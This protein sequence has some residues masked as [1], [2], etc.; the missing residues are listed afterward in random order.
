MRPGQGKNPSPISRGIPAGVSRD[1]TVPDRAR[2][3][4]K[5]VWSIEIAGMHHMTT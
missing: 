4:C 3:R 1:G 2:P 5:R